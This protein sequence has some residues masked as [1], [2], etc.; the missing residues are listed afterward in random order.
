MESK[1]TIEAIRN[2]D[3]EQRRTASADAVARSWLD[4]SDVDMTTDDWLDQQYVGLTAPNLWLA[5]QRRKIQREL[6]KLRVERL[7]CQAILEDAAT[8][9]RPD[10]DPP[11]C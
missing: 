1:E 8:P 11:E 10:A 6:E 2:W 3:D 7:R 4:M 5:R 9:P